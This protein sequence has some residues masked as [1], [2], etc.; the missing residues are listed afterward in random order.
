M[1]LLFFEVE[2]CMKHNI[3]SFFDTHLGVKFHSFCARQKA[4]LFRHKDPKAVELMVTLNILL[5]HGYSSKFVSL[6]RFKYLL[7]I[8]L[9]VLFNVLAVID[10]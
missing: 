7:I 2:L 8:K 6:W 10:V 5:G 1:P 9:D 3:L 4:L